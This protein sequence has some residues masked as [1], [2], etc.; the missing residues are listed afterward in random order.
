MAT[1]AA[2]YQRLTVP[3]DDISANAR[4]AASVSAGNMRQQKALNA[5]DKNQKE[6]L[7]RERKAKAAAQTALGEDDFKTTVTGFDSRDDIARKYAMDSINDFIKVGREARE[8]SARGDDKTYQDRVATQQKILTQFNNFTNNEEHLKEISKHWSDLEREG[9]ISPV[10]SEYREVMQSFANHDFEYTRDKNYNPVVKMLLKDD[11]GNEKVKEIQASDLVN[12]KYRPYEKVEVDGKTGLISQMM[13]VFGKRVY[14]KNTGNFTTTSKEWDELNQVSLDANLDAL[15]GDKRTMSSLL[16]QA[17]GGKISKKG[18]SK[19]FG[20]GDNYTPED[21][22]MVK[23][24]IT[25]KVMSQY[26]SS[27]EIKY[28]GAYDKTM[29]AKNKRNKNNNNSG[30]EIE[31]KKDPKTGEVLTINKDPKGKERVGGDNFTA[32]S[33][34]KPVTLGVGNKEKLINSIYLGS[35]DE[36]VFTGK[37]KVIKQVGT[38]SLSKKETVYE[39]VAGGGLDEEELNDFARRVPNPN[40]GK[41]FKDGFEL[42]NFLREKVNAEKPK[43]TAQEL[44]EK[45]RN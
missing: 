27:F 12:G 5:R 20:K 28:T 18:D 37:E 4:H 32:F 16:Y 3:K 23:E 38:G 42:K 36:V 26:D 6:Q 2:A 7:T 10:D 34:G 35:D 31:I 21:I 33:I 25:N 45:Y 44:I 19:E 43:L 14:D 39:D 13:V 17:S 8:A 11:E 24:Y 1:G 22:K 30:N 9:K 15:T 29:V 41:N 40:T